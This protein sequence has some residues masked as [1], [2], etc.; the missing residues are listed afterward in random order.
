MHIRHPDGHV[1][2]VSR[3][4][5]ETRYMQQPPLKRMPRV[6]SVTGPVE[7]PLKGVF[8]PHEHV[9]SIFG[10]ERSGHVTYDEERLVN[11]V[12]PYLRN[13]KALGCAAIADCTAAWIGR[14][15]DILRR[16]SRESGLVILTN[17][18]YYG[19]AGGRY[20]PDGIESLGVDEIAGR[21]VMEW[22]KGIDGT[23]IRPGFIKTGID[24]DMLSVRDRTLIEAAARAHLSTGLL[25]QTHT[26]DNPSGAFEILSILKAGGVPPRAWVW[27]HAHLVRDQRR[28]IPAAREGAWISLDGVH[29][30]RD[31][32]ILST[33]RLMRAEGLLDRI[34]LSH[35]GNAFTAD[36]SRRPFEHLLTGF[37][38]KFLAE[39]FTD[40][41]YSRLTETNPSR[42][43]AV[44]RHG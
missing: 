32:A 27:V 20:L 7:L 4:I 35:D 24:G 23:V 9:M 34:L 16:I 40:E 28:L 18:G 12:V 19:A 14:R 30:E 37:R 36:G 13:L 17:T 5:E 39:G 38:D 2:R 41:E 1:F 10:G 22:E 21:W 43:F 25:I 3:G 42:A 26:G 11:A 6:I 31:T 29:P 15:P 33:L 8:L 44:D